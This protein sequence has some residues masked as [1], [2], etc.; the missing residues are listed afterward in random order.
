MKLKIFSNRNYLLEKT[1]PATLKYVP[2]FAPFWGELSEDPKHFKKGRFQKLTEKGHSFLE[3]TSLEECDLAIFPYHWHLLGSNEE[4][5]N[6]ARQFIK[7]AQQLGKPV[8]IFFHGD[9]KYDENIENT[10]V[11]YTSS[12]QSRRKQNEFAM[13]EW[14]TDFIDQKFEGRISIRDKQTK[15][16]VGFCGYAPPLGLPFGF[17]K[18]KA[19]V[20]LTGDMVG[21]SEKFYA[22]TGHTNRVIALSNLAKSSLIETKF[23]TR[24]HFAFAS[25]AL[26]GSSLEAEKIKMAQKLRMEYFQNMIDSDYVVC[27]SGYENYSIRLYETLSCGRIPVFINTDCVLPYDFAIDWKKYCVWVDQSELSSIAEKIVDF[28]NNLSAEE[29]VN[30]QHRCRELWEQLISPEGF[31]SNLYRHLEQYNSQLNTFNK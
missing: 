26:Q 8:A 29:F 11:F 30:L 2:I 3:M 6:L 5:Y 20:R 12:F 17:K 31:F 24:Q 25:K 14:T 18:I 21:L 16:K 13:P 9:W 10:I 4:V 28:H 15:P 7:K 19:F 27:C 22:K 1:L 23:I